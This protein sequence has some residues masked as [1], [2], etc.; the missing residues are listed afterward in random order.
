MAAAPFSYSPSMPDLQGN[1]AAASK[2]FQ[3]ASKLMCNGQP[4]AAGLVAWADTLAERGEHGAAL[5][6]SA[7]LMLPARRRML[8]AALACTCCTRL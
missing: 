7:H 3:E 1:I 4:C 8:T 6:R 2:L 5:A